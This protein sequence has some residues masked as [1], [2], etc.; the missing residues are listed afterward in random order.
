[1]TEIEKRIL[2]FLLQHDYY[3]SN[4]YDKILMK[5]L[6]LSKQECDEATSTLFEQEY[7]VYNRKSDGIIC[8]ETTS[9]GKALAQRIKNDSMQGVPKLLPLA[10]QENQNIFSKL[11]DSK[12]IIKIGGIILFLIAVLT[13][14]GIQNPFGWGDTDEKKN[15]HIPISSSD[16]VKKEVIH[17]VNI[18]REDTSLV[19]TLTK[20][21][22]S[23]SKK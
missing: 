10:E 13:F 11:W 9:P 12:S 2:L 16:S 6:S 5:D 23:T 17:K 15:N 8:F 14:L 4:I 3:N 19:K 18:I 1:M 20:D 21:M 7:I 22:K